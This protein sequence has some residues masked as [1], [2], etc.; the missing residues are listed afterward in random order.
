MEPEKYVWTLVSV[1]TLEAESPSNDGIT[2]SDYRRRRHTSRCV[3][4]PIPAQDEGDWEDESEALESHDWAT[5]ETEFGA[6]REREKMQIQAQVGFEPIPQEKIEIGRRL[7]RE[8]ERHPL[9]AVTP[10][11]QSQHIN[12]ANFAIYLS[13]IHSQILS[14]IH[15]WR[16]FSE[17]ST[18]VFTICGTGTSTI[19]Q[20]SAV[21]LATLTSSTIPSKI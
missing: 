14:E 12:L 16:T 10:P 3:E 2:S 13:T 20:V 8:R 11:V 4:A 1:K 5:C 9:R 18:V 17:P 21:A 7:R 6:T 15:S 19:A